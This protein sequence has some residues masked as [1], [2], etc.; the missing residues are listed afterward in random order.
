MKKILLV[1]LLI[2]A[3]NV[4]N[5]QMLISGVV[6]GPLSGGIPKAVEFYVYEDIADLSIFG[7]GSANNGG[8]SDGEEFSFPSGTATAGTYIY[9]ASENTGFN[10]F[11]GFAPDFTSSAASINGDDAIELFKNG[12][13]F[14]VYGD[15]NA[16][17]SGTVW[18]YEDGW[19]YR[20]DQTGPD[21]TTF[22]SGN[23]SF[24]GKNALDG[25]T[26]NSTAA[27]P[28]P[29]G[30]FSY[31]AAVTPDAPV[32]TAAASITHE[33]FTS[34]WDAS[35]GATT[36]FL[37]VSELSDF[38]TFVTGYENLDVGNVT[39]KSV[40]SLTSTTD[41][42]YRVRANNSAGTSGNSNTISLTTT[43]P[44]TT[45]VQFNSSSGSVSENGGTYN[46][47]VSISDEDLSNATSADVVLVTGDAADIDNYT[48]QSVTFLAGSSANETVVITITDDGVVE[49]NETLTFELQN[50]VGG[51]SASV[52]SPSQF[53]LT[54]I[55]PASGNYYDNIDPNLTTFIDD[56][57]NRIRTPYT[58]IPYSQVDE[59]NIAN[60][61]SH[62]NGDGTRSVFCVYSNY[63]HIYSGTFSWIPLSREH[64]FPHS[65]M[66]TNPADDPIERDEY[67]D[68]HH[69]FPTHQDDANA[70]RSNHPLGNVTNASNTFHDAKFGTDDNGNTV[71]EPRDP[72]KGDAARA[73]LYMMIRYD[74]IDGYDWGLNW[75]N[76]NTGRDPQD[77]EVLLA[78]HEQDPP[79]QWELDR[80]DYVQSIQEN[81]N[82]FVDH[83]EYVNYIDFYEIEYISNDLFFSEYVEGSSNNK[84]V[85]IFN[86]TG[87]SIDLTA[88]D[89]KI[90]LY[91]NGA[92]TPSNTISLSGVLADGDVYVVANSSADAAILAVSDL[93]TGSLNFNGD[94]AIAL[95]KGSTDT[96]VIGQIGFDPGDEWGTGGISTQNNTIRRNSSIGVGDSDGS[97]VFDP[98]EEWNGFAIDTFDGLGTH[99]VNDGPPTIANI[100]RTHKIPTASQNTV[101][102]ADVT[103]D[104]SVGTVTLKYSI[105]GGAEQDV[106]MTGPIG[107]TYEGTVPSS[108]YTDGSLLEYWIYA[109]DGDGASS[110]SSHNKVFTG[111]T[112]IQNLQ[113][114]DSEG[115]LVHI[116][117]YARIAG[118]ATVESG[119]F[120]TSS[121]D[122]YLQ[123]SNAGINIYKGG[124]A[125]TVI[126]RGNNYIIEGKLAQ[127]N[128]KTELIPDDSATDIID[129]GLGTLPKAIMLKTNGAGVLPDPLVMT[130]ENF[131][132]NPET[133]EGM[134]I[135][136]QH[137]TN[138]GGG[139]T[140]PADGS[141][142]NIEVTDDGGTTKLTLRVD[143]DT[144]LDGTAEPSWPKDVVGILTQYDT[145][146][147]YDWGYQILPR[148]LNDIQDDGAL[149]V[150]LT[151]FSALAIE[152]IV[153]LNWE[154]V[155]EVNNYGFKIER[156]PE[157]GNWSKLGFVAGHGNSNSIKKYSY[158]DNSIS[159]SGK[160]Q[161]RLKQIDID[162][163]F[164]YLQ[165]IEVEV[166]IPTEFEVK[167]NYPNPFNPTTTISFSIPEKENVKV[168][169]YNMLGEVVKTLANKEYEA[170]N[171]K[172]EFDA[173]NFSTGT[174]VYRVSAG[175]NVEVKKMILLK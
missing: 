156:K 157:T 151:T 67:A 168:V 140:W 104:G 59:T 6:D 95:V 46:L 144:E 91:S 22:N 87:M 105:D 69:L 54:I 82:P 29:I 56:L 23:W 26:S 8:G 136:I 38:S 88:Q 126:V 12:S 16:D 141:N 133:Y 15:I 115:R 132:A 94:D 1:F 73:I 39:S 153:H 100:I 108:A 165:S 175:K 166:G 43:T 113:P 173:S 111:T 150:E 146:A 17:G 57:K 103:D 93:T 80:N 155:T 9:V 124:D 159:V 49:G 171:Y 61:T 34:N 123:D 21:G 149:P 114:I 14:D 109:E 131:L 52:G 121:L 71:Y 76:A 62:D 86:N 117:T 25:E 92:V 158:I 7:F 66:P 120:S 4:S 147:P 51:N 127:Y 134:L 63:E 31:G 161:Y 98:S 36:Y 53:E 174:Y 101:V 19:A 160:Y 172:L 2:L 13:V 33:S 65:W 41:Y 64:T 107:S 44:S 138:T 28:F 163:Q 79:D 167:Q 55:E 78:W 10:D 24:S 135:G 84:A 143:K 128:G 130:I 139:D 118:V 47:L 81:R 68:Q 3:A 20:I 170:G 35:S 97:D 148:D 58:W 129:D 48:T 11:F 83:P 96:D 70:V 50:I 102:S 18:D 99:A 40:T 5:G 27:T 137:L 106:A 145:F 90:Q 77:I 116:Q 162:G 125:T 89:Y 72:H 42:F 75:V 152:N 164:E 142:A 74:D 85:E 110:T 112:P 45:T 30:T 154:T 60:F 122:V 32:A 169:I 37:D 119:L